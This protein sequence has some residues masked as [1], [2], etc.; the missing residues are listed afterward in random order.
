MFSMIRAQMYRIAKSR[1]IWAMCLVIVLFVLASPVLVWLYRTWSAFAE[2]GLVQLPNETLPL[3][4]LWGVSIVGGSAFPMMIGVLLVQAFVQD[5]KSGYVKNLV[6]ARGGRV[7]YVLST[8]ACSVLISCAIT[9]GAAALVAL[10]FAAQGFPFAMPAGAEALGWIAQVSLCSVAYAGIAMLALFITKSET[11]GIV[12]A[13][14][15]GGGAIESALG[16]VLAN[17]PGAP[18]AIRDCLDA[19]LAAGFA[20]LGQGIICGPLIYAQA[21]VTLAAV[22]FLCLLTVRRKNLA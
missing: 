18:A 10:A 9:I 13:I 4:R 11:V 5:F 1:S 14:L 3:L 16:I 2:T 6:Q 17:I 19:Y 15:T 8:V 21:T 22:T 20:Q 7:S 12:M